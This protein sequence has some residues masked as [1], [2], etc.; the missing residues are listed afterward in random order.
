[1]GE[2][3]WDEMWNESDFLSH[4]HLHPNRSCVLW[5]KTFDNRSTQMI[6]KQVEVN[7]PTRAMN[8]MIAAKVNSKTCPDHAMLTRYYADIR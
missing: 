8:E 5:L 3:M 4:R 6:P 7:W 2:Q 1:M